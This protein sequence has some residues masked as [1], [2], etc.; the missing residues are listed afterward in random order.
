MA[1]AVRGGAEAAGLPDTADVVVI[2]PGLGQDARGQALLQ[3]ALQ[4]AT[5]LVVDA[6]ALNLLASRWPD[7]RRDD[8]ILTPHPGK[9]RGC[10]GARWPRYRRIALR[11]RG[12]CSVPVAAW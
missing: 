1:R 5:P 11:R 4:G 2:G 8:W 12:P 7:V 6:D 3:S 10:W 9:P